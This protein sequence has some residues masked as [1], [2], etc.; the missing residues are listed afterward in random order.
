[1]RTFLYTFIAFI[2]IYNNEVIAQTGV[3]PEP[4]TG[5]WEGELKIYNTNIKSTDPKATPESPFARPKVTM[6]LEIS[7][8][9]TGKCWN[10]TI[11]YI[12][13]G[14]TDE[15]KYLL[16]RDSFSGS[17]IIDEQNSVKLYTYLM[18]DNMLVERFSLPE[19]DITSL[20]KFGTVYINL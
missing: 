5:L 4:Y 2:Y 12:S 7:K 9:D 15:R 16:K 3:F 20:Y 11:R 17:F 6:Q 13:Q 19:N 14:K 18:G 1:M 8:N 10:F